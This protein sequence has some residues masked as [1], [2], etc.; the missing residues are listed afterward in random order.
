[1]EIAEL[2]PAFVLGLRCSCVTDGNKHAIYVDSCVCSVRGGKLVD[3]L[4][5]GLQLYWSPW[6]KILHLQNSFP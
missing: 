5:L 4:V 6:L 3:N 1:M 2:I